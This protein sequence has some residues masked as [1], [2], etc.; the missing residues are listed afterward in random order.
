[1]NKEVP[2]AYCDLI[3]PNGFCK[4]TKK[5][6]GL[7]SEEAPVLFLFSELA[8]TNL[9]FKLDIGQTLD[10]RKV[11]EF[12]EAYKD[13]SLV[14]YRKSEREPRYQANNLVHYAV[15]ATF[16]NLVI[17]SEYDAVVLFD[18][19]ACKYCKVLR[20]LYQHAAQRLKHNLN[21][22]FF[23]INMSRNEVAGIRPAAVQQ[24][25]VLFYVAGSK[26][27]PLDFSAFRSEG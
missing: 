3:H 2:L 27:K 1:M 19:N 22:R 17:D 7:D 6:L 26:N 12:W 25:K 16:Q 15:G 8:T 14:P 21:I 4:E 20:H 10:K 5:E 11:K 18:G 24:H 13:K 23:T 9:K